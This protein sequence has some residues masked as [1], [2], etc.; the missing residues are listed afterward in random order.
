MIT[1]D[2]IIKFTTKSGRDVIITVHRKHGAYV[3][4]IHDTENGIDYDVN[5]FANDSYLTV[6]VP[7]V[8][9]FNPKYLPE[10]RHPKINMYYLSDGRT[11]VGVPDDVAKQ[12]WAAERERLTDKLSKREIANIDNAKAA[13]AESRVLPAE[14]LNKKRREYNN[15]YNEGGEGY[16]PF[17]MYLTAE[18]IEY[19]KSVYPDRF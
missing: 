10:V 4:H 7:G 5:R 1:K 14:E 8:C 6:E 3:E 18:Y 16:N 12:I 19:L 13:I 11:C 9:K 15:L 17:D 2:T